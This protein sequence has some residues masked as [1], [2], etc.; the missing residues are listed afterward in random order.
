MQCKVGERCFRPVVPTFVTPILLDRCPQ[1]VGSLDP[2]G[3][4]VSTVAFVWMNRTPAQLNWMKPGR[5]T[6][7]R[8]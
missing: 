5:S 6:D 7:S 3:A 4:P 2:G 1:C 8:A